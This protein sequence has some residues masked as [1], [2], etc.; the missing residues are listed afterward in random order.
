[1]AAF[2]DVD[3]VIDGA[4]QNPEHVHQEAPAG[5]L[6]EKSVADGADLTPLV[7]QRLGHQVVS[8]NGEC[9]VVRDQQGRTSRRNFIETL[10]RKESSV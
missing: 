6:E 9:A 4:R 8:I 7:Q 1:M 2:E 3:A 10:Y 5:N